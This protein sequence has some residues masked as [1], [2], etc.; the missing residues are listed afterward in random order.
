MIQTSKHDVA[1]GYF[2]QILR[3]GSALFLLPAVLRALPSQELAFW[4]VFTT[5]SSLIFLFDFGFT[6]T[7]IRN[8]TYAFSGA[9]SLLKE[10]L[11]QDG[12]LGAPNFRLLKNL[13][14]NTRKIY[15][16]IA[17]AALLV[18]SV[19]GT[20]YV[21]GL[22]SKSPSLPAVSILIA[23][24]IFVIATSANIYFLYFN[25]LLMGRGLVR[26]A[27]K[28][29]IVT[30]LTY[31]VFGYVGIWQGYG[32]PALSFAML[33][34]TLVNRFVSFR[35]FF[36]SE[37]KTRLSR[38]EHSDDDVED[39]LPVI[40]Y[41]AR[42]TGMVAL[43]SF[44][45]NRMSF[46]LVSAFLALELVASYG[47]TLQIV[48]F[49]SSLSTIYFSTMM[50]RI[51][52]CYFTGRLDEVERQV[53]IAVVMVIGTFAAGTL[54]LA[55]SGNLVLTFIGSKTMLLP[56]V[57]IIVI[58]IMNMLEQQHSL[59][60]TVLTFENRVPFVKAAIISG[61]VI[62]ISS[63]LLLEFT[64]LKI[65]AVVATQFLVQLSYNNWRWPWEAARE[66]LRTSYFG[67][68]RSGIEAIFGFMGRSLRRTP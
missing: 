65:W 46:L 8:V 49:I 7:I 59:F 23:W 3:F 14:L 45:I 6:P 24:A 41:N 4:Y 29:S 19:G 51:N 32:L 56:T 31:V 28:A 43:G 57:F 58:T 12:G 63:F 36:D 5:I 20:I 15:G 1:W 9:Q 48:G 47:L 44:L 21:Q 34:A 25:A 62:L 16:Y 40:W 42:K 10:G 64:N 30:S 52:S 39:L 27:Q 50:P 37:L 33:S 66:I 53:G 55:L 18:Q 22:L 60:A 35:L 38:L 54:A 2:S 17:A 61:F 67:V 68:L 11:R 26:Q 13:I